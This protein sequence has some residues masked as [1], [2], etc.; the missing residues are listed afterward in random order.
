MSKT[1]EKIEL[2]KSKEIE[3]AM[4]K[5]KKDYSDAWGSFSDTGYDRYQKKMDKYEKEIQEIE[6]YLHKGEANVKD[7]TTDQYKEYLSMKEDIRSLSSKFFFLLA[8]FNLPETS[9][10]QGMQRILEKYK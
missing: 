7:L 5:L 3:K 1:I 6:E 8:D 9:E 10:I 4:F 2:Y